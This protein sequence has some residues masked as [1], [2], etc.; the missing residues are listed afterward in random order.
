MNLRVCLFLILLSA[1]CAIFAQGGARANGA[2][3]ACDED[4][5]TGRSRA[6]RFQKP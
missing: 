1:P 2:A 3:G 4:A 6:F 5:R